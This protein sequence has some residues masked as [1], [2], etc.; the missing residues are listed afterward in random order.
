MRLAQPPPA[1]MAI[2][3]PTDSLLTDAAAEAWSHSLA[4]TLLAQELPV[5]AGAPM[6]GDWRLVLSAETAGATVIPA[7]TV[8]DPKGQS[9]GSVKG[10]PVPASDWAAGDPATLKAAADEE[11]PKVVALM[12]SIEAHRQQSDPNSLLNRPPRIYLSGVT[13]APGDGNAALTVQ[14]NTRLPHLGDVMVDAAGNADFT[15]RGEIKTAPGA[16]KS[17]RVEIQWIVGDAK[18]RESGRVVQINEVPPGTLDRYW[19]EVAEVVA[20]EAA[21]GVHEVIVQA[22]GRGKDKN[23]KPDKNDKTDEN[24]KTAG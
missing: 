6:A 23:D 1:R 15:V 9:E 13:G 14:M 17:L 21:G 16:G 18:G 2:P 22:T 11:A 19:G 12:S 5:V 20:T 8:L 4:D 3:L 10:P 24:G 7:Y